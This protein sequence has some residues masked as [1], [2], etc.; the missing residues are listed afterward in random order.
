MLCAEEIYCRW[1][2]EQMERGRQEGVGETVTA[3][4]WMAEG[5]Q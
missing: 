4:C 1:R 2:R 5:M 3:I